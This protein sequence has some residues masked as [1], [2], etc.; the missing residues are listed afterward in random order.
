MSPRPHRRTIRAAAALGATLVVAGLVA[1][2]SPLVVAAGTGTGTGT[3][4][5]GQ[6]LTVTPVTDLDPTGETVT[7]SGTGFGAAAGFDLATEGMYVGFCVDNGPGQTPTP[8]V[9]GV[10]LTGESGASRWIT[11]NPYVGTPAVAVAADGSFSTTI[12]VQRAD[13]NIDCATLT[14]GKQCKVTIRMD[15]RAGGDRSQDVKVPVTFG[16]ATPDPEPEL[17]VTPSTGLDPAGATVTVEGTGY[18]TDGPGLYVVYGPQPQDA[19]DTTPYGAT[20]VVAPA[21]IAPDGSFSVSLPGVMAA[22]VDGAGTPRDFTNGGG[23]VSTF[24]AQGQP[25]PDGDWAASAPVS[26]AGAEVPAS[27]TDLAVAP[28][29][30]EAGRAVVMTATVAVGAT[31]VTAGTVDLRVGAASIGTATL[32]ADGKATT[33]A[34]F[35]TAGTRAVTAH[36]AGT[37]VALPSESS[38]VT[39]TVTAAQEPEEPTDPETPPTGP[40]G[41]GTGR[42]VAGQT[43]T[44]TPVENLAPGGTDVEVRGAGFTAAAGFDIATEGLYVSFCVD[45]GDGAQPSPCVGGV[46][47]EGGSGSSKWV[48]NNPYEGVPDEAVTAVAPDGSFSTT[49]NVK[50]RDEFVDCLALPAGQRC[51]IV[52]R[53]DHRSTGDRTQDVKVQVCFA[54]EAACAV[55]PQTVDPTDGPGNAFAGYALPPTPG[56]GTT[57]APGGTTGLAR[58]GVEARAL[59]GAG[60]AL[61]AGGVVLLTWSHRRRAVPAPAVSRAAAST[62]AARASTRLP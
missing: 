6:T 26:F 18:P 58:T 34:S 41:T 30:V 21:A 62:G 60:L 27:T 15:H 50:A 38:P 44:A 14:G 8:C 43:L 16:T 13:E 47:V 31:P 59:V 42:G 17:T 54:G 11:N 37:D 48:T 19:T 61:L 29:T 7:V 35:P 24:R 46:D 40:S 4:A 36:F 49:I 55:A 52:A 1:V 51:V 39:V 28:S 56:T 25:D 53:M 45:N 3:G 9:G 5:A 23:F 10:D 12:T 33:T 20:A 32:G 22:Y 57:Y 2:A